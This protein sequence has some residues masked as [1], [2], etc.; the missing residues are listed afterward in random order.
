MAQIE[1]DA[2]LAQMRPVT[3][4][5]LLVLIIETGL[6]RGDACNLVFNPVVADS[7]GWP[8]L[9]FDATKVRA[10]QL[11]PLSAKA[12]KTIRAQQDHVRSLFPGSSPWLFPGLA[13]NAD[14]S[15]P[16]S[17]SYFSVQ[18]RQ[19]CDQVGLHDEAG[20]PVKISAH[21]F[22]HT[23]GT[24]LKLRGPPACRP[25]PP[26]PRLAEHDRPIAGARHHGP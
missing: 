17:G 26:R 2:A 9:R 12:A 13:G 23:F 14:G 24:R 21:Q 4:R 25:A 6:R 10:E 15:K 22:R 1:P 3:A 8:C 5:N 11:V 19:W 16:Y 7:T 18:L 20:Q